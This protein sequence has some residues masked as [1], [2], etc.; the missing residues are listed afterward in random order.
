LPEPLLSKD[1]HQAVPKK[2]F[3]SVVLSATKNIVQ[4]I[5]CKS[6]VCE[7]AIKKYF[8]KSL[9]ICILNGYLCDPVVKNGIFQQIHGMAWH[10]LRKSYG[11]VNKN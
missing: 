5:Y 10:H 4:N 6:T 8:Q 9:V 11:W 3:F 7:S 2:P 1:I